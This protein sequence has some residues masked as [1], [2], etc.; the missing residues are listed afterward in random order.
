[1]AAATAA[2]IGGAEAR[3]HDSAA[4]LLVQAAFRFIGAPHGKHFHT[5][6]GE[7]PVDVPVHALLA[8]QM[9][10]D[11]RFEVATGAA[12]IDVAARRKVEA[13]EAADL[14][15]DR[16]TQFDRHLIGDAH[17]EIAVAAKLAAFILRL[18]SACAVVEW[19]TLVVGRL[20]EPLAILRTKRK[21]G[22][23]RCPLNVARS[24]VRNRGAIF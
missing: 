9:P 13:A 5:R 19:R 1:M 10:G 14:Q 17:R 23:R 11:A 16:V 6:C 2:A 12:R 24:P 8:T 20:K 22:T 3:R 15:F 21:T 4:G 18:I 7:Q